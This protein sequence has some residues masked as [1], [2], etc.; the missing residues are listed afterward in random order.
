VDRH[1]TA[2]RVMLTLHAEHFAVRFTR[3]IINAGMLLEHLAAIAIGVIIVA[4]LL[5]LSSQ[6]FRVIFSYSI[7]EKEIAVL[8]FHTVPI[9][10]IPYGKIVK[11]HEAPFYEVALVPGVHLFTRVFARRVVIE[12]RDRWF[13]FAFLTPADPGAFMAEVKQRMSA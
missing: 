3:S 2:V 8:L 13:I 12:M 11:M 6:V 5:L 1:R 9:Y 7:R 10:T 4:L